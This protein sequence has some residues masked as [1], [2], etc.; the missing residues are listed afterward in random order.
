MGETLKG[1]FG[2]R[3]VLVTILGALGIGTADQLLALSPSALWAI[4]AIVA[5][6][7]LAQ[8]MAD[9]G[10]EKA[11][12]EGATKLASIRPPPIDPDATPLPIPKLKLPREEAE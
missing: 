8:G 9:L 1:L 3:K 11:K 2:S 7:L 12:V 6:C 4:A 10:K 5:L